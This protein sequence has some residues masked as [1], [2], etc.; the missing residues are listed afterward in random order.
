M[1]LDTLCS[2]AFGAKKY[3]LVGLHCQRAMVILTIMCIPVSFSGG[4]EEVKRGGEGGE[5]GEEAGEKYIE[6]ER[7]K[8]SICVVQRVGCAAIHWHR[9]YE[10]GDGVESVLDHKAYPLSVASSHVRSI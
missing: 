4:R 10:G 9:R 5:G 2:Q 3:R 6:F 1:A 8:D 7:K